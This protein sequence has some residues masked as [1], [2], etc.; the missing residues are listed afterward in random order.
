MA[1]KTSYAAGDVVTFRGRRNAL[2][3]GTVIRQRTKVRKGAARL[4]SLQVTGRED[5]LDIE[6]I[7]VAVTAPS[8]G[9]YLLPLTLVIDCLGTA[10]AQA[11]AQVKTSIKVKRAARADLRWTA[12]LD[13]GFH[14]MDEGTLIQVRYVHGWMAREFMGV[15]STSGYARFKENGRLHTTTPGNVRMISK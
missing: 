12:L 6:V 15:V 4:L 10:D 11:A 5:S 3:Q 13:Q 1:T 9:V 8:P 14:H 2:L 7:E